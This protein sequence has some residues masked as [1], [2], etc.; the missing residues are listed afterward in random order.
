MLGFFKS[1]PL[2]EELLFRY[3][4]VAKPSNHKYMFYI[5]NNYDE[6]IVKLI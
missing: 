5:I 3:I 6:L 1:K 4:L 2:L